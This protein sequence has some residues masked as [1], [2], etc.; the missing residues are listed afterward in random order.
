MSKN[1]KEENAAKRLARL[2]SVQCLYRMAMMDEKPDD[3]IKELAKNPERIFP[4]EGVREVDFELLNNILKGV[5]QNEA[6]LDEIIVG[7]VGEDLKFARM[8][9]LLR[10][11]LRAGVYEIHHSEIAT[12]IIINDYLDVT[13]A[14]FNGNEAGMV[15]GILDKA[16]KSLRG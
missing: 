1:I 8:E 3:L 11:T 16:A 2:A 6:S 13:H 5:V 10:A 9:N 15:N 12:G 14:F 7:C 4:G